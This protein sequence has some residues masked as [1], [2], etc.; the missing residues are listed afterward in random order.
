MAD[1]W[2]LDR[3]ASWLA[4]ILFGDAGSVSGTQRILTLSERL[5]HIGQDGQHDSGIVP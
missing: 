2:S 4:H 1:L 3:G 5:S